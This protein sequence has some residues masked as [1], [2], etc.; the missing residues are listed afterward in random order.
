MYVEGIYEMT[1]C[2]IIAGTQ[3]EQK[4]LER[5]FSV[6][7]FDLTSAANAN[8]ALEQCGTDMPDVIILPE[9]M[10]DMDSLAFIKHVRR[11]ENGEQAALFLCSEQVDS[12]KIG[13]AIWQ[14]ASDYLI[15]PFDAEVLDRKLKQVGVV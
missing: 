11:S 3:D 6:Y 9:N 14:G 8:E 4:R 13:R 15:A 1:R 10:Q 5:M 12:E 7:G 2:M